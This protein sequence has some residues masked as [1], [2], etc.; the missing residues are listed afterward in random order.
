MDTLELADATADPTQVV[1]LSF[2]FDPQTVERGGEYGLHRFQFYG[3]GRGGVLG[4][5]SRSEVEEAFT[6][7]HTGVFDFIWDNARSKAEP[8]STAAAYLE[9]A[10]R[11]ADR[12]FGAIPAEVLA[13][14][15][16]VTQKVVEGVTMGHHKLVDGYRQYP[17]PESPV[18]AAYLGAILMRELRGCVH[19]DAVREVG[20]TPLQACYLQGSSAFKGHGYGDDDVPEVSAELEAKKAQAEVLTNAMMADCFSVLDERE[21]LQLRDG[22]LAMFDALNS[23]VVSTG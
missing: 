13:G 23:P 3:L 15:A 17:V 16:Q 19:I 4:D 21:R 1:G 6:F 20:L 9:A 11:F 22:A 2:Y 12:T 18:H 8:V 5:V 7:F 14:Y 10:Y